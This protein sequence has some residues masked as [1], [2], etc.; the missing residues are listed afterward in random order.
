MNQ[1]AFELTERG[2]AQT[3]EAERDEWINRAL[4]DLS[5]Y[6]RSIP[7]FRMEEFRDWYSFIPHD[8]HVWGALTNLASRRGLI[9]WTGQYV[10]SESPKTHG[11]PVK[12][13]ERA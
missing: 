8:P 11:H 13:W 12:L 10:P 5:F 9:Q 2:M 1:L 3:L 7:V 6:A 4:L